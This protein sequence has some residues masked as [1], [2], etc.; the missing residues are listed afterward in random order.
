M[1]YERWVVPPELKQK[2]HLLAAEHRQAPTASEAILWEALRGQRLDGH[3]FRR[4]VPIGAF[5]VDF[6]CAESKLVVEVDGPIHETQ[7]DA[8]ALRQEVLESLGLRFVRVPAD[9]VEHDLPHV[10]SIVRAALEERFFD[11]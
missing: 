1:G 4:Q 10:L 3:K 9:Q 5:I 2:L 8:D 6:L 7:H 11:E